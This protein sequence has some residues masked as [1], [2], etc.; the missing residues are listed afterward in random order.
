MNKKVWDM[1]RIALGGYLIFVGIRILMEV[2]S[3]QPS[4][5]VFLNVAA[6]FFIFIGAGYALFY[7]KKVSGLKLSGVKM[8]NAKLPAFGKKKKVSGKEKSKKKMP[9]EK[10]VHAAV[11]QNDETD[12]EDTIEIPSAAVE[13][14]ATIRLQTI[15]APESSEPDENA[16]Q[17]EEKPDKKADKK[18]LEETG[19]KSEGKPKEKEENHRKEKGEAEESHAETEKP[20]EPE[21]EKNDSKSGSGEGMISVYEG[22]IR[23]EDRPEESGGLGIEIIDTED[24]EAEETEELESDYEER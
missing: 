5:R 23:S 7:A 2:A 22:R 20:E 16:G 8:P 24:I 1:L 13:K 17:T 18:D 3:E 11:P 19:E 14:A 4:N 12:M 21:E 10:T 15:E 9:S 6:V